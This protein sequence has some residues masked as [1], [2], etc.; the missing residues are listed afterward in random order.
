MNDRVLVEALRAGDP[1]A[2]AAL[3]D[4]H[5]E[6]IYRY[7]WFLLRNTD[8]AQVAL[9]D[10]LIAA[11][12]HAAALSDPG[13]LRPWL[14]ALARGECTRRRI[15]VRQDAAE[16]PDGA[17]EQEDADLR[18]MAA[19]AVRSL[20][21]A[22]A[23]VLDLTARHGLSTR[24]LAPVL[25]LAVHQ[26]V[27]I[28]DGARERLRDAI[29]AEILARKGPY[30][31]PPRARILTGFAGELTPDM[32][33]RLVG[34]LPICETCAPHLSRQVSAAKVFELLPQVT[35]P[36]ATR[37]RVLSCVVDPELFLYRR[38]VARRSEALDAAGFPV[39]GERR[40]RAWPRALAGVAAA[41]ATVVAIGVIFDFFGKEV[42]GLP[43]VATVA[44][45]PAGEPPGLT[46]PWESRVRS[47][48]D[49]VQPLLDGTATHPLGT[50]PTATPVSIVTTSPRPSLLDPV[51]DGRPSQAP[52]LSL[53]PSRSSQ[54][55]DPTLRPT[56]PMPKPT[57]CP[58][59]TLPPTP[60]VTPAPPPTRPT[61]QPPTSPP[62]QT[63][64]PTVAPSQTPPTVTVTPD[65]VAK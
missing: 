60:T 19:N 59:P 46:L 49:D 39:V 12:A 9:R 33:R 65:S 61:T 53:S 30:D 21:A 1:G 56:E 13:M 18:L 27:E 48:R 58:T 25:G 5:A 23:E 15:A 40:L 20:S 28:Y 2:V 45:P 41:V 32:R 42:D 6:S 34:H 3:Y 8:S 37:V 24:E 35:L 54:A 43:G 4:T 44:F 57:P 26:V 52:S 55:A 29:T 63:A 11:E 14:Y 64:D 10:V 38:Y 50:T 22:D 36:E 17:P 16:A 62:P 31:C 7:C 51:D 47:E